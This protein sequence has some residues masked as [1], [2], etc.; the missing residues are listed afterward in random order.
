MKDM[1]EI[2]KVICK[3]DKDFKV[4]LVGIY[5]KELLDDLNDYCIII[6]EKFIF[7]EIE[8]CWKVGKV[9]IYYICCIEF[10][11]NIFI[12]SEFV[13]VEWLVWYSVK[14][15]LDGYFCWVLNSWVKNFL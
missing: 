4:F 11:F 14:E 5:Y 6:V 7:E 10:C 15:N 3:V 2:L 9:I 1:Q 12:F 8:V 13:E